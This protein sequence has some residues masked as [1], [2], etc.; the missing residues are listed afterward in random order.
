[1]QQGAINRGRPAGQLTRAKRIVLAF[2]IAKQAANEN[3]TLGQVSRVC[4]FND[5][6]NANKVLKQLRQMGMI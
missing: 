1:M 5:R 4:G 2:V 6:S 3:Y